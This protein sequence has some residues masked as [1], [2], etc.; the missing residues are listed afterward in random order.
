MEIEYY[1]LQPSNMIE[2]CL[3]NGGAPSQNMFQKSILIFETYGAVLA[4]TII[5]TQFNHGNE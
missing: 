2:L 3:D 1:Y 5:Q 4:P